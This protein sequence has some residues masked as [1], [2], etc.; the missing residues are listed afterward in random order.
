[1][2]LAVPAQII[3]IKD[4]SLGVAIA[5][6]DGV[7]REVSL[8]MLLMQGVPIDSFV[9]TWVLLHVGFAMAVIDEG[10]AKRSLRLLKEA[11]DDPNV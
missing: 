7:R 4:A 5:E 1:M 8:A 9:G 6:T 2:C 10:E 11:H 3:A